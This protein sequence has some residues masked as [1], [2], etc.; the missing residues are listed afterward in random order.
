M[1]FELARNEKLGR[2]PERFYHMRNVTGGEVM[3]PFARR[4][5]GAVENQ[6]SLTYRHRLS[7]YCMFMIVTLTEIEE[8]QDSPVKD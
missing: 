4:I 6:L 2:E 8:T 1:N 5:L 3:Y 7:I